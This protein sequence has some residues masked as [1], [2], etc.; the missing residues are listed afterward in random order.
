MHIDDW[1][2]RVLDI[3]EDE[4][5]AMF[6]FTLH[7]FDASHQCIWT[8]WIEKY[9]L[10]CTWKGKRYRVTGCSRLGDVWLSKGFNRNTGYDHRV[11]VEECSDWK[12]SP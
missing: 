8:E 10:Y 12:A 9:S 2:D 4:R 6:F 1:I 11:D 3:K 5:Y 7:R